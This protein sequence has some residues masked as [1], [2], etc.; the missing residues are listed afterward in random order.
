MSSA[1]KGVIFEQ[2]TNGGGFFLGTNMTGSFLLS[3]P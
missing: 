2:Q 3:L 1:I